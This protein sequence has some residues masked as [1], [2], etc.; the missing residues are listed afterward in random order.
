MGVVGRGGGL[1]LIR[2]GELRGGAG[3][4]SEKPGLETPHPDV[5]KFCD[6]SGSGVVQA[7]HRSQP[8]APC[9]GNLSP[10]LSN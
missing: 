1:G 5:K 4:D 9:L 2:S 6:L 10:N 8:H 7:N 3:S